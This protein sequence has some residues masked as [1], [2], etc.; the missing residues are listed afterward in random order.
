MGLGPS[1]KMTTLHH[2]RYPITQPLLQ[3]KN[4]EC[5]GII[6]NGVSERYADKRFSAERT[7]AIAEAMRIDGVIVSGRAGRFSGR[8]LSDGYAAYPGCHIAG[9]V[10]GWSHALSFIRKILNKD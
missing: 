1:A 5:S 2:D 3:E 6:V 8:T 9:P 10:F 4:I 7:G